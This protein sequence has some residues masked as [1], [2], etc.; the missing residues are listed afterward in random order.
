MGSVTLALISPVIYR[1]ERK[2][3]AFT[4][5]ILISK[6]AEWQTCLDASLKSSLSSSHDG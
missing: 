2:T 3:P 5:G 6:N 4:D 1:T